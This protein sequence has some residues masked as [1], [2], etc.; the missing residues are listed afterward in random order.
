M[1][2]HRSPDG[3]LLK[4]A[5][6]GRG[7]FH[8][9]PQGIG[10]HWQMEGTGPAHYFQTLG[11]G[12]WLERRGV[13]CLHANAV[14][15]GNG[16]IGLLAPSRGGKTTLTAALAEAGLRPMTDDMLA[17]HRGAGGWR[18][19]PAWPQLRMW[20]DTAIRYATGDCSGLEK[21]HQ[22]FDKRLVKLDTANQCP[23]TQSRP[24][25][26]L[27]LLDRRDEPGADIRLTEL[28]PRTALIH[29]LQN[30]ILGDACQAL[31]LASARLA[32]LA[33]LLRDVPLTKITYPSGHD[34]LPRVCKAIFESLEQGSGLRD[35]TRPGA[36]ALCV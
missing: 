14:A 24:L 25:T 27:Y 33:D 29:L 20:P 13:P 36:N 12:I 28:A 11:L 22:R 18:V 10:T 26:R 3:L 7:L 30:S 23:G 17:L 19:F 8:F 35:G 16:A 4:V 6:E 5:C 34:G 15:A 9:T 1:S 21:V 2:L 31:G 32:A